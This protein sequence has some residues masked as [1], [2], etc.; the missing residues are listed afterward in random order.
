LRIGHQG[1]VFKKI[2]C[3]KKIAKLLLAVQRSDLPEALPGQVVRSNVLVEG[4][5]VP[6]QMFA[7]SLAAEKGLDPDKPRT[8][9]KVTRTL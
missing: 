1:Q 9:S 7:A 2:L 4:L 5:V 8:L 6:A 3:V